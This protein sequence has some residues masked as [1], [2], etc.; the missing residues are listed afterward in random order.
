LF[1][2]AHLQPTVAKT[3]AILSTTPS[4]TPLKR[5][6]TY[7]LQL[8]LPEPSTT[9][10]PNGPTQRATLVALQHPLQRPGRRAKAHHSVD[11]I[12]SRP[13][14]NAVAILSSLRNPAQI[15]PETP[16]THDIEPRTDERRILGSFQFLSFTRHGHNDGR[17]RRVCGHNDL[18]VVVIGVVVVEG[19]VVVELVAVTV[20]V[21][22]P[23]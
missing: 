9:L 23:R 2:C 22:I 8:P 14:Q 5:G 4:T 21:V 6:A 11:E 18:I 10:Q 3:V 7:S 15:V 12:Q 19:E 16:T 17:R 13:F 20:T 1:L